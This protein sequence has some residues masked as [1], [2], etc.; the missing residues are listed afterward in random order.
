MLQYFQ[1]FDF[2]AEK[3]QFSKK[4][5]YKTPENFLFLKKLLY[6]FSEKIA[7]KYAESYQKVKISLKNLQLDKLIKFTIF[8][9]NSLITGKYVSGTKCSSSN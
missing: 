9:T 8:L 6:F 5:V 7:L 3:L 2:F 4:K 1:L